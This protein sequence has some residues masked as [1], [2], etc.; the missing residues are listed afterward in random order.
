MDGDRG[1]LAEFGK[2]SATRIM[3]F[4]PHYMWAENKKDILTVIELSASE[5]VSKLFRQLRF[6]SPLRHM[7]DCFVQL[8]LE[9]KQAYCPP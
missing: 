2:K 6:E 3:I 8:L 4:L 9:A 1:G 5:L 7:T